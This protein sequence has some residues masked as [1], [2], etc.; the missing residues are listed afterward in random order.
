M[1]VPLGARL[2]AVL[3]LLP[4]AVFSS[5]VEARAQGSPEADRQYRFAM[6]LAGRDDLDRA[7]AEFRGFVRN[8]PADARRAE[9]EFW[10]A[11]TLHKASKPA[12]AERILTRWLAE[13]PRHELADKA[14][15]WRAEALAAAGRLREARSAWR[16]MVGRFPESDRAPDALDSLAWSYFDAGRFREALDR[17]R[18]LRERF[19]D[20][21]TFVAGAT[22]L[23]GECLLS[24]GR[25]KEALAEFDWLLARKLKAT[26]AIKARFGRARA[27]QG[28][29]RGREAAREYAAVIDLAG[30]SEASKEIVP[31]AMLSLASAFVLDRKPET[32]L[33]VVARL[34]RRTDRGSAGLRAGLWK[35]LALEDLGRSERA[36]RA[37]VAT[38]ARPEARPVHAQAAW[39]L[40]ELR[41]RAKDALGAVAAYDK[42]IAL[43]APKEL[44]EKALYNS[45]VTL[46][47][48]GRVDEALSRI[49]RFRRELRESPLAPDALYA[50]GEFLVRLERY[51]EAAA[52]YGEFL[53]RFPAD[54]RARDVRFRRGWCL[55]ASGS[56]EAARAELESLLRTNPRGP[57]AAEA[58]FLLGEAARKAGRAEEAARAYRT[59]LEAGPGP[60]RAAEALWA[61]ASIAKNSK[62]PKEA[63]ACAKRLVKE[64]PASRLVPWAMRL[65]AEC[66]L[67]GGDAAG[68]LAGYRALLARFPS[69]ELV[70]GARSG[71]AW[72]LMKLGARPEALAAFRQ[73]A[74]ESPDT[75]FGAEALYRAAVLLREDGRA[76]EA[77]PLLDELLRRHPDGRFAEAA[78][79]ERALVR[80]DGGDADGAIRAIRAFE[81]RFPRSEL[82]P[83]ALKELALAHYGKKDRASERAAW[84]RLLE[85]FGESP[86]AF[87]A[88]WG[89]AA[90]ADEEGDIETAARSYARAAAVTGRP[91]AA[92]AAFRFADCLAR[93]GKAGKTKE[94]RVAF[95]EIP[96][97]FPKSA[98]AARALARAGRLALEAGDLAEARA[99]LERAEAAS[100]GIA[101]L[102]L[103][104]A[105]RMS[106]RAAEALKLLERALESSPGAAREVG[107]ERALALGEL[108]RHAE[109]ESRLRDILKG[110][111]D[112]LAARAQHALGN[113]YLARNDLR[114]AEREFYKLLLLCRFEKWQAEARF[115]LGKVNEKLHDFARARKFYAELVRENGS[116]PYAKPARERIEALQP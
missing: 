23:V 22:R 10:L 115:R 103:G 49:E 20:R 102:D 74:R 2:S 70:P 11:Y 81:R 3:V 29:G 85:R 5:S 98:E 14:S 83:R 43:G 51:R 88:H 95:V 25:H 66:A 59:A 75:R 55:N 45:A 42:V 64:C 69:H 84:R 35:G 109:A 56:F 62:R 68:A 110:G 37:Y 52:R 41:C 38:L 7:A 93:M 80:K 111:D 40:A 90:L 91:G 77:A 30:K 61:L 50:A 107:L 60:E 73:L 18:Q 87:D 92:G 53:R 21:K 101:S 63:R 46:G 6:A 58:A 82:L 100:P 104:R 72:A 86:E 34:E 97:R 8:F 19:P 54:P 108:G 78:H 57:E 12:E 39:Q 16:E 1:P 31:E 15:F 96:K 47:E 13:H 114:A 24:L 32:A 65:A 36:A 9:V 26:L 76:G 113:S 71:E 105:L 33:E 4:V 94:A 99:L 67:D 106:G 89:I 28:L 112:E 48:L 116:S 17:F 79:F 27:L 44:V